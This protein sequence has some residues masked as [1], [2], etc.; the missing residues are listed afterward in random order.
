MRWIWIGGLVLMGWAQVAQA[1]TRTLS[2]TVRDAETGEPLPYATLLIEGTTTGTATNV[3]GYFA[4]VGAPADTLTLRISFLGFT[5]LRLAVDAR[6]PVAPLRIALTPNTAELGEVTVAAESYQ[7]MKMADAVS[8]VTVS[9]RDLAVLPSLGEVDIFRSL[10]LLPG[11]SATNEGS[12]GLFVRGGTPDQ[13][14][15]L[16]DGMTVYHVDHFFGFFSAFNADAVQDV[17]LY[18]G[19]FPAAYGGRTSSVVDLTG[20]TGDVNRFRA[21]L[22]GNLL[23][24]QTTLEVPLG[25]R[26]SI[27]FAGRRSYTDVLQSG[28]YN[29][30]YESLT[31]TEATDEP[32]Q[33]RPGGGRG[34]GNQALRNAQLAEVEPN[35][36]FYDLNGKVTYRPTDR[37]VLGLSVYNGEDHLDKSRFDQNQRTLGRRQGAAT[38]NVN[39]DLDDL[40]DWGNVGLSGKWARQ[41]SARV[42]TTAMVA[43]SAYFSDYDRRTFIQAFDAEADTLA[44]E[45]TNGSLESNRVADLSARFDAEWQASAQHK[46]DAGV[47]FSQSDV[48]YDFIRNDTLSILARDQQ[49]G[50]LSGYVQDAWQLRPG[51]SLTAG[52]R[53]TYFEG[54][55]QTYVE[56]RAAFSLDLTERLRLKG[57][58]GLYHQFVTRIVNE[59]ITEG[60]RDFW[61]LA[62][63]ATVPVSD[64]SHYILG[65]SYETGDWLFDVEAYHKDLRGLTEFSLRFQRVDLESSG[66][67]FFSG[68]GVSQGL[69]VLAQR[70][71]GPLTG[72]VSYTLGRIDHTFEAFNE[73]EAFPALHD[74]LHEAKLVGSYALGRWTFSGTWVYG[75]GKPYTTPETEYTLTLLDGTAFTYIGVGEKN[76]Q[77]LPAY[78][79][80]DLAATFRFSLGT[81]NVSTSVSVFNVYNRTNVWYREFD[82][83]ASPLVVTDVTYLGL[84]PNLAFRVDL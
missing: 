50:Q 56:P 80:L 69:E 68:T 75:S 35:F 17:Q 5:T 27:L 46:I 40:T 14:L 32:Q 7:I 58:A 57:A 33:I 70:K 3:E 28:V 23:S 24:G 45:R 64:A 1:Q 79:R 42:F 72:W 62:D 26:G 25:G 21:G 67:L 73:G 47:W 66:E 65:A 38:A 51:L 2:G 77:R 15:V 9:P 82:L 74:Q 71:T 12:S 48:T 81:A 20:R 11:V 30:I 29:S 44:F 55:A 10:Q 43:H 60:A 41:W 18:K 8:Q 22:G 37:D 61:L 13:N 34:R 53:A 63:G 76:G 39:S 83:T 78:H 84:T 52:L 6:D 54:T 4:L 19:G 31:G 16:L 59:N 36:Y 49:A